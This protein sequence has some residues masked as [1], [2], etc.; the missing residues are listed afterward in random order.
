MKKAILIFIIIFSM[1]L[2]PACNSTS[3]KS[4]SNSSDVSSSKTVETDKNNSKELIYDSTEAFSYA[5]VENGIIITEFI[6]DDQVEY[7]KIY[8]PESIDGKPV[9]G[10]G[11]LNDTDTY[12]GFVFVTVFGKCEIIIP[13]SVEY[14]GGESFLGS[15]GL[16]KLSGGKNCKK[17]GEYA[18][19]NCE[20]L[21][22]IT[23]LD[24]VDDVAENAFVGCTKLKSNH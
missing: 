23:F 21:E 20:N 19:S 4:E 9:V 1:L 12:Y 8:I 11:A 13:D 15:K 14:I 24:T 5:E 7:D 2:L 6:N 16:V 10:I 3:E 18:F 17:I 22:E